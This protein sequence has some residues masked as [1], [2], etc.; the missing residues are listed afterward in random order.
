MSK[1]HNRNLLV[2]LDS[3]G[4]WVP[5]ADTHLTSSEI[6][7][8]IILRRREGRPIP[9]EFLVTELNQDPTGS[10]GGNPRFHISNLRRKLEHTP[11]R[12][13]IVT[14]TGIGYCLVPGRLHFIG[15]P[16]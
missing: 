5:K 14:R 8:L 7:L 1:D 4:I 15:G 2:D 13:V 6:R 3:G 16:A 11:E 12:P 9:L 10:G